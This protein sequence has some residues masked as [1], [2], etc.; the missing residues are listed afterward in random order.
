MGR[1]EFS[2]QDF[3][4]IFYSFYG[5]AGPNDTVC[6]AEA[7]MKD[8]NI[9]IT[10]PA[11]TFVTSN[12]KET[13]YMYPNYTMNG[14]IKYRSRRYAENVGKITQDWYLFSQVPTRWERR[15]I[16]YHLN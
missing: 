5:V 13:Q 2:S 9:S 3:T 15:L 1:I 16:R 8:Q 6:R 4:T 12:F 7:Q 14:A 11:G 10:T